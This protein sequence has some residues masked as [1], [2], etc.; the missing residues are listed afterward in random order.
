ML[1]LY[2]PYIYI[3]SRYMVV[4]TVRVLSEGYPHFPFEI[5]AHVPARYMW[6]GIGIMLNSTI[7]IANCPQ[8]IPN[9]QI[10]HV[11]QDSYIACGK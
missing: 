7:P 9:L 2:K 1:P 11:I 4:Y 6:P 5:H 10:F 3:Y 8:T